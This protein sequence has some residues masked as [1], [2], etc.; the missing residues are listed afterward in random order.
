M[1]CDYLKDKYKVHEET[2]CYFKLRAE[3]GTKSYEQLCIE[4][5]REGNVN[6]A[7][8]F[9]G[10]I[11]FDGYIKEF[12][13][14][15]VQSKD[16]EKYSIPVTVYRSKACDMVVAPSVFVYFH[17]GGNCVGSRQSVD[18]ICKIF[19][20]DAP[21]VVVNVEYRLAP[22]HKWPANQ[23]D[24][25]SA[26]R[27]VMMNKGLIGAVNESTVGVGGDSAGGRLAAM[28]CHE[29]RGIKY[30]VLVYPS[31]DLKR[32]GYQSVTEFCDAPGLTMGMVDWFMGHYIDPS[33]YTN[34]KAS[35]L[36][37]TDTEF[38]KLPPALIVLA[39]LDQLRDMGYAYHEKLKKNG[40]K[41]QTHTVKG[42]TH[43]F[44]HLPEQ[45]K[46]CCLRAHEKVA[47]F[48]KANS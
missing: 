2:E 25:K 21:C 15:A 27:W 31:V 13:V 39:E 6:N 7:K 1:S 4:D 17:G 10:N 22:E 33:E 8:R 32:E 12:S 45:F 36:Y 37:H 26:V 23:E 5:A 47:K 40:V 34:P 20:R 14:P 19:S 3:A 42:V 11:E 18:S 43:G 46:E 38:A 44:F 29:L 24:A 28:V 30:Q 16:L 41:S 48:I 9:G 35:P